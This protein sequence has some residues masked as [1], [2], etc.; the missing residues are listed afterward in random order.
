VLA[1]VRKWEEPRSNVDIADRVAIV[2]GGGTGIGRGICIALAKAGARAI[3]VNYSQSETDANATAAELATMGCEAE[4]LRADVANDAAVRQMIDHVITRFGQID[5]LVNNAGITRYVPYPDI[6]ALEDELWD[7]LYAVNVK[8]TFH[9]SRAAA[10]E[11]AKRRGAI[12]NI[13]SITGYRAVGSSIPYAVSKAAVL[14]LTRALAIALAP[15]IRV[16]SVSPGAVTTRL[17]SR[18]FGEDEAKARDAAS[19]KATPLGRVALP[20]DVAEAVLA[21]I[22]SDFLTGEDLIVDGG[23]H[24]T[25]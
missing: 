18:L 8:G 16:N 20:N 13:G 1:S 6:N 21:F 11:L 15:N 4:P 14:Q 24:V 17:L 12:V 9:C 3:V 7:T 2:T 25:Y 19:A 10:P 5:I 22:R 23:R